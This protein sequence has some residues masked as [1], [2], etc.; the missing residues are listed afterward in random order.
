M[1]IIST[2]PLFTE[3]LSNTYGKATVDHLRINL[4]PLLE[5]MLHYLLYQVSLNHK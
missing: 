4:P 3:L 2:T 5:T 1:Y